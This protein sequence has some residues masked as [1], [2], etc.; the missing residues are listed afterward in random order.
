MD[1]LQFLGI[2]IFYY[3]LVVA[4]LL[5]RIPVVGKFFNII[6]TLIHE[7]GHALMSLILN[8]KVSTI[9][10]F[11]DTSG[12]TTT[13][14]DSKFKSILVSLAGY[15]FASAFAFVCFYLLSVGYTKWILVGLPVIFILMLIFWIRNWYGFAWVLIFTLI[16]I[17]L[18]YFWRNDTVNEAI[19]WFYSLMVLV[20]SVWSTWV[21]VTLSVKTPDKAGDA[22]N[23]HR[24]THIPSVIWAV[25]FALFALLMAYLSLVRVSILPKWF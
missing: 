2:H 7:L 21:L 25:L 24:F 5:P 11:Q 3:L 8:G 15:P 18:I 19:A 20:E 22:T 9:Q 12:V 1:H 17:V 13:K 16:N 14:S 4:F 23:L 10:I 6:N